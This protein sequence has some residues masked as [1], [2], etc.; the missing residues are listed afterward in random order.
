MSYFECAHGDRYPLFGAGGGAALAEE[1]GTRLV[2]QIPLA[3]AVSSGGDTGEPVALWAGASAA[4][5]SGVPSDGADAVAQ[6]FAALAE[7]VVTEILPP[8]VMEGCTARLLT[9]LDDA[10]AVPSPT[11]AGLTAPA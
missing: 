3:P 10:T 1:T 7:A 9:A 6:A 5:D 2:A 11:P 8:L 4:G